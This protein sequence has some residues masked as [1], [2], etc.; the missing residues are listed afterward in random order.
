MARIALKTSST[1][2]VMSPGTI[3]IS[4]GISD[5]VLICFCEFSIYCTMDNTLL[6]GLLYLSLLRRFPPPM[7]I[8]PPLLIVQ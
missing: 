5:M 1:P 3:S 8:A 2:M 7:Q 6:I 4:K